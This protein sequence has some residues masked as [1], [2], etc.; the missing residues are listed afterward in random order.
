[1]TQSF[2][3]AHLAIRLGLAAVFLWFGLDKFLHPGYWLNAWMP[4][5]FA[6]FARHL[7]VGGK[8]LIYF[9]G[10]IEVLAATSLLTTLFIRLF[11]ALAILLLIVFAAAHGL[12]EV[13]IRDVGLVGALMALILWPDRRYP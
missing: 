7:G 11:A 1:M 12:G 9:V 3:H 10:I 2:K 4:L 6:S 5:S 13:T 8:E